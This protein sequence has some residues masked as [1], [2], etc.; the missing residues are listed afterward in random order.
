MAT[1]FVGTTRDLMLIGLENR[2]GAPITSLGVG[3]SLTY[4]IRNAA[5]ATIASGSPTHIGNG[6]WRASVAV[7]T[8]G[9]FTV[10]WTATIASSIEIWTV[11]LVVTAVT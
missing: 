1:A 9:T 6:D 11:P 7:P 4:A 10:V 2:D 8:A 3:D 5:G